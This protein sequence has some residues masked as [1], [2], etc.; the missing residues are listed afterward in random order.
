[1]FALLSW[2]Q[3]NLRDLRGCILEAEQKVPR[4]S[5]TVLQTA[6]HVPDLSP[7]GGGAVRDVT[8]VV[9]VFSPAVRLSET[10]ICLYANMYWLSTCL[11]FLQN[12]CILFLSERCSIGLRVIYI[13]GSQAFILCTLNLFSSCPKL[14]FLSSWSTGL[15]SSLLCL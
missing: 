1:M 4:C 13:A 7:L 12:T 2:R 14:L 9:F 5:G 15:R 6:H 3:H 11:T 10:R 8:Q